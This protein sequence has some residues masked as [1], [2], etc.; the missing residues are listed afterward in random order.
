[1]SFGLGRS[2]TADIALALFSTFTGRWLHLR[3]RRHMQ[4]HLSICPHGW[5]PRCKQLNKWWF[6]DVLYFQPYIIKHCLEILT[7][8]VPWAL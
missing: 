3:A 4:V 6:F 5:S 7:R 1:M 8:L 2:G